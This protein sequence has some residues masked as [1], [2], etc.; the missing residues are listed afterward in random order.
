VTK[1]PE[2]IREQGS[3]LLPLAVGVMAAGVSAVLTITVL[4]R[5]V[6]KHSFGAFAIYRVLLALVVFSTIASRA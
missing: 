5:Y 3:S 1:L 2:A 4:L 6:S